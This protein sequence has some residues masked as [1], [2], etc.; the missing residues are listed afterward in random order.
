[1]TLEEL[2]LIAG[3][4]TQVPGCLTADQKKTCISCAETER[5]R[6][7]I[8]REISLKIMDPRKESNE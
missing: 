4:L 8:Q 2:R 1:M 7:I 5:A 6:E 3:K